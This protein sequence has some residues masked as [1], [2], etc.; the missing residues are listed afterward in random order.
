[1]LGTA[2]RLGNRDEFQVLWHIFFSANFL[3]ADHSLYD[4]VGDRGNLGGLAGAQG[5]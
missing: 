1:M 5:S 4:I 2:M 3:T